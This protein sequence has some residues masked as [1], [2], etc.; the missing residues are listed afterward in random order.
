MANR[1]TQNNI[2]PGSSGPQSRYFRRESADG[3]ETPAVPVDETLQHCTSV[4]TGGRPGTLQDVKR[5]DQGRPDG[6]GCECTQR[7]EVQSRVEGER[8]K[9]ARKCPREREEYRGS[10]LVS[11]AGG[12][13]E[14]GGECSSVD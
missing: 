10:C 11:E 3:G 4:R 13:A 1:P 12:H 9:V 5:A 14:V 6:V 7:K 2:E 8:Q